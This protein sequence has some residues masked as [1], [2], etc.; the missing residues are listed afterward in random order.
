MKVNVGE[1]LPQF[2]EDEKIA[3][4]GSADFL[5]LN[6][7][8][9]ALVVNQKNDSAQRGWNND[10]EA[11][12]IQDPRWPCSAS[13]WLKVNPPGF[14]KLLNWLKETYGDIEI[15]VTESG[16][17]EDDN[18]AGAFSPTGLADVPRQYYYTM[19]INEMLK[20]VVLDGVRVTSYTAW[21]LME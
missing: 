7:Y 5:G 17:S 10:Q 4:R 6:H 19:Y 12:L 14:R 1:R 16:T 11:L 3:I 8:T 9:S 2:T 20:A 21:S 15:L 13:S 18:S